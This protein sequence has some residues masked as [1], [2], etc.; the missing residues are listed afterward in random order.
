MRTQAALGD[1]HLAQVQVPALWPSVR[2]LDPRRKE[3][4]VARPAHARRFQSSRQVGT[5][6][7]DSPV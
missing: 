3:A 5:V 1:T 2:A 4:R 7:S 6:R